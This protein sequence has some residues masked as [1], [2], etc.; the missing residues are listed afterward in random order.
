[1]AAPLPPAIERMLGG[2]GPSASR[3]APLPPRPPNRLA[4]Q[5]AATGAAAA[6]A[7]GSPTLGGRSCGLG[8]FES[9]LEIIGIKLDA[10]GSGDALLSAGAGTSACGSRRSA[11][12]APSAAA[13]IG[14]GSLDLSLGC[15]PAP[16][17]SRTLGSSSVGGAIAAYLANAARDGLSS[18]PASPT[19][20]AT[21]IGDWHALTSSMGAALG[22]DDSA[23]AAVSSLAGFAPLSPPLRAMLGDALNG[24]DSMDSSESSFLVLFCP[25]GLICFL[26]CT[27]ISAMN[28]VDATP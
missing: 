28:A 14:S 1:M 6:P 17:A 15:S 10:A 16:A 3:P 26:F 5:A 24:C 23:L 18:L 8:S 25:V 7:A 12:R 19:L 4:E 22:C 21:G 11:G 27:V 9:A 2:G 20:S 13:G